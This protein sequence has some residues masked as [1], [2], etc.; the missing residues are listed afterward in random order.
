MGR[1]ERKDGSRKYLLSKILKCDIE[2]NN[3]QKTPSV[4]GM[5]TE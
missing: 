5:V 1:G 3:T 2:K 4:L